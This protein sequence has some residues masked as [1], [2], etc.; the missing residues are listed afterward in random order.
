MKCLIGRNK[1]YSDSID[2]KA[3]KGIFI[4]VTKDRFW[5]E[6]CQWPEKRR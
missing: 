1:E 3:K 6:S 2:R 5:G 4:K